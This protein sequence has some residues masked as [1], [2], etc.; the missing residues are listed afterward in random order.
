MLANYQTGVTYQFYHALAL[1]VVV[2]LL[3]KEYPAD[4]GLRP[5]GCDA[6]AAGTSGPPEGMEY[7]DALRTPTFWVLA[8]TAMT[9]FYSVMSVSSHL[10]LHLR[11]H[12]FDPRMAARALSL[13]FFAGLIGKF[14][15]GYLADT[16]DHRRVLQTSLLV[17]FAGSL[18]LV[19]G[20]PGLLWPFVVLFGFG[21]GG[22][23]TILQLVTVS[24]FGLKAAGKILGTISVLD[25]F[26]GGLGP[27]VT[28][29]LFDRSQ[30][31]QGAFIVVT[32]ALLA[33][34]TAAAT[35]RARPVTSG[36]L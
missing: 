6:D 17:M 11:G 3:V 29:L 2:L 35:M 12:G 36:A 8:V 9:T 32:V 34:I 15:L 23:Y 1:F 14:T 10:F 31:Y 25:A 19:S 16:F 13:L 22:I 30:S 24:S 33:A 7:A 27:W 21:W 28:G 5:M 20:R 18:C 4:I 26:G